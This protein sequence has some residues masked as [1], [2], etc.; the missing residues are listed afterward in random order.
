MI[1]ALISKLSRRD[2]L[3]DLERRVLITLPSQE[4]TAPV[5]HDLIRAGDRPDVST[6]VID[7]ICARYS[8]LA[9]GGRQFTEINLAG[10]FIDLHSFLMK[11]M[12]HGVVAL[13][14]CRVV[15][16]P[17]VQLRRLSEEQPHLTRLLWLETV[18]DAA[19]HRQWLLAMGRQSALGRMAHLVCE[20]YLRSEAAGLAARHTMDLPLTQQE[21]ADVLGISAVHVNRTLMDLRARGLVTWLNG[22]LEIHDWSG[23]A[24]LAEFE[25]TYLRLVKEPV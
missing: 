8:T 11:Q 3:S 10:D 21:L 24:D 16:V 17:H 19:I 7:G 5:G 14:A 20:L 12:D 23:L 2:D 13:T 15:T 6:L 4:R 18:V 25:P 9:S 1:E 22:R